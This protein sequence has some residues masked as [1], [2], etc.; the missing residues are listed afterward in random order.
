MAT[1]AKIGIYN[2]QTQQIKFTTCTYD[3]HPSYTGRILALHYD[4]PAKASALIEFGSCRVLHENLSQLESFGDSCCDGM[5]VDLNSFTKNDGDYDFAYLFVDGYWYLV[6]TP[7]WR[8]T[9]IQPGLK[10][11]KDMLN[12]S[13]AFKNKLFFVSDADGFGICSVHSIISNEDVASYVFK[14]TAQ[15]ILDGLS[16]PYLEDLPENLTPADYLEQVKT[17]FAAP[18][19]KCK[20]FMDMHGLK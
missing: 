18:I 16:Y 19:Q 1:S 6:L 10:I 7:E 4:T 9:S 13:P 17:L 3:G 5:A 8:T 2:Y 20:D 15:N 11:D 12:N 14:S